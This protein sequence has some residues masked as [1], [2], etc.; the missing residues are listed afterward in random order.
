VW[1]GAACGALRAGAAG[2]TFDGVGDDF[3]LAGE[4]LEPEGLAFGLERA[5]LDFEGAGLEAGLEATRDGA[6]FDLTG[7]CFGAL[8]T[9]L[10]CGD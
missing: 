6:G 10:F 3:A 8:S 4:L 9:L 5:G 7:F 2:L 1:R